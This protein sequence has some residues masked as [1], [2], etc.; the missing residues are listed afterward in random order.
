MRLGDDMRA[1]T[2]SSWLGGMAALGLMIGA[3]LGLPGGALAAAPAVAVSAQ[4]DTSALATGLRALNGF[5]AASQALLAQGDL[6]AARAA[7]AQ[8][9]SGWA[10]IEDGVR[11]LSRDNYRAI[12]DAMRDVVRALNADPVDVGQ[13]NSM[14]DLLQSR[15]NDFVATLPQ[16]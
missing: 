6:S 3:A 16:G 2:R 9:D 7:Y 10:A 15:V 5:A 14:L 13:A 4:V 11:E 12:E 8:F 1:R